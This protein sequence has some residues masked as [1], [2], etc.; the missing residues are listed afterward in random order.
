M[1]NSDRLDRYLQKLLLDPE[2]ADILKQA[3][4][5]VAFSPHPDDVEIVAG[6]FLASAVERGAHVK[7]VITC[8]DRMS[9]TSI[10]KPLGME[11]IASVRKRE[12]IEAMSVLGIEDL[13]FL[14]YI[15]SQVPESSL[16]VRDYL[17][18][19]R[20]YDPDLAL[21]VDPYLPY[22][23]HPDHIHT[24]M[25]VMRAVLFHGYPYIM[26]DLTVKSRPPIL[27][28]GASACPNVIVPIDDSI[29]RKMKSILAHASQFPDQEKII[30]DIRSLSS[31]LGK[32]AGFRYGEAFK[33]LR[34]DEIH[35]NILAS[36][37]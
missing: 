10:E 29:D 19:M 5:I 1:N 26:R 4:R 18:I 23:A 17:R 6:G 8:D 12:E 30:E 16:L 21:T 14:E 24:G 9:F 2:R 25:G 35:L 7:V 33:V 13:E 37:G 15:D 20:S 11:E 28:L 27:A 3:N 22:E 32:Y 36:V 31:A 34:S